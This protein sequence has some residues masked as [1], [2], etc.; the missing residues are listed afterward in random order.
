MFQKKCQYNLPEIIGLIRWT[1]RASRAAEITQ[2]IT[3]EYFTI[4]VL[5]INIC[6][7]EKCMIQ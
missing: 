7:N 3:I 2:Y 4:V 1:R 6:A 5:K